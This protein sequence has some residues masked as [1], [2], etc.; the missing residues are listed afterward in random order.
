M[1]AIRGMF[2]LPGPGWLVVAGVS[3]LGIYIV[4][5]RWG[6]RIHS[7]ERAFHMHSPFP[8]MGRP[9]LVMQEWGG[10]LVVHDLKTRPTARVYPS[11]KLQ[12]A[13]YAL[14]LRKATGRKVA[15]YAVVR[16]VTR[17]GMDLRRVELDIGEAQLEALHEAFARAAAHPPLARMTA[18]PFLCRR[19]GFNGKG[20]PGKSPSLRE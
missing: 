8:L 20:C 15:N 17:S 12:L 1:S 5:L 14:L 16:L 9:D 7:R 10:S 6:A 11:D 3:L 18:K 13:L 2:V 4:W 19:C